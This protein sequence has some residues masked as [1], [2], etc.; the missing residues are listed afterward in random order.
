MFQCFLYLEKS[1]LYEVIASQLLLQRLW[2]W[3]WQI[4]LYS[5]CDAK[6]EVVR[7]DPD[8]WTSGLQWQARR[9]RLYSPVESD[10]NTV[11]TPFPGSVNA[12]KLTMNKENLGKILMAMWLLETHPYNRMVSRLGPRNLFIFH[13]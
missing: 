1:S 11:G 5:H 9:G 7:Y 6:L 12:V 4:M 8:C 3:I 13:S 10:R 2:Q